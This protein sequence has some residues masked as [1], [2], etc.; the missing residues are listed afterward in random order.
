MSISVEKT[1]V[2]A[3]F[4]ADALVGEPEVLED[5][6]T[7]EPVMTDADLAAYANLAQ[8]PAWLALKAAATALQGAQAQDGSIPEADAHADAAA[9]VAI[10]VAAI[11][12]LAPLFPHDAAYLEVVVID[13]EKWV[14]A[15]FGVPDFFDALQAFQPQKHRVNGL[16]H[17]VVFPMY[18][19]NGSTSRLVE[20]VLIEV[21]W[22]EFIA[23]LE[24]QLGGAVSRDRRHARGAHLHL[25]SHFRRPG[26]RKVPPS[27]GRGRRDH[28]AATADGC[29]GAV[30]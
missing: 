25:G 12:E 1:N 26:G 30:A 7:R 18:T 10:I 16:C 27:G 11:D 19:Q 15:G 20:A 4:N 9:S 6:A 23:E 22:P 2:A 21:I 5:E 3:V 14:A 29:R 17:L 28:P 8:Q 24:Q 13:F